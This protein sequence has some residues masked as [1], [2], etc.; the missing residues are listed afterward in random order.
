MSVSRI[1]AC[2]RFV[3]GA[4]AARSGRGLTASRSTCRAHRHR[5]TTVARASPPAPCRTGASAFKVSDD[6]MQQ[7]HARR[8]RQ[9][10]AIAQST[11]IHPHPPVPPHRT[12]AV[13]ARTCR[14]YLCVLIRVITLYY[15]NKVNCCLFDESHHRACLHAQSVCV[16]SAFCRAELISSVRHRVIALRQRDSCAQIAQAVATVLA[17]HAVQVC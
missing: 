15:V 2:V 5:V 3:A 4:R 1:R 16:V 13:P 11:M 12:R 7:H 10:R 8:T 6:V 14:V 17:S 9:R